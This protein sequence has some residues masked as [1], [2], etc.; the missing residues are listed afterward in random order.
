MTVFLACHHNHTTAAHALTDS[1]HHKE[2]HIRLLASSCLLQSFVQCT[3]VSLA[4]VYYG[5]RN[6][7]N[8][9]ATW[10]LVVVWRSAARMVGL[11]S[12]SHFVTCALFLRWAT[13]YT[14]RLE[15]FLPAFLNR[16][17]STKISIPENSSLL[18]ANIT[19]TQKWV[20]EKKKCCS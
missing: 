16:S 9:S 11:L 4:E 3:D 17:A 20:T 18:F 13:F 10:P 12:V 2:Y 5:G 7:R 6:S 8:V 15:L 19:V 1:L 14:H